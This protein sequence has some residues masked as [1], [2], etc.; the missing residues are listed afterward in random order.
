MPLATGRLLINDLRRHNQPLLPQLEARVRRVLE[1]GWYILGAEVA[2]FEA[3]F[4]TY[5]GTAQC[6]GVGNGTDALELALRALDVGPGDQ[7]ATVANAG[8]YSK[9]AIRCAGAEPLY[10][11]ID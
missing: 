2:A 1:S 4:A 7:V 10:V 6:V 5:C 8:G 3:S 11:D 9:T